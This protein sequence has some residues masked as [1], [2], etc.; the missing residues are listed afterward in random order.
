MTADYGAETLVDVPVPL[1]DGMSA[2]QALQSV[3]TVGTAYGGGFVQSI[4]GIGSRR[5]SRT[6]WFYAVN[7]C[8]RT[9]VRP[10]THLAAADCG[11]LGLPD[12]GSGRQVTHTRLLP[13]FLVN[14]FRGEVRAT[15]VAFETSYA[16]DAEAMRPHCVWGRQ[17]G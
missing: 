10:T 7:A 1:E 4:D 5:E 12:V 11:A 17:R 9:V 6:D 3:A 13:C 2:M 8:S 14:G 16:D 15:V